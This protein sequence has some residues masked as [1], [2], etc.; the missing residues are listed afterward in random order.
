MFALIGP[1]SLLLSVA[2]LVALIH[3]QL[4]STQLAWVE[5]SLGSI[6]RRRGLSVLVCGLSALALRAALLPVVGIPAPYVND[7][8]SYLL[9]ADTFAHG[10]LTNPTHPMW[11]HFESFH[12]IFRPTYMSMY[13]PVQ[14]LIMAAGR[15]IGG[16]PFWGI[17]LSVG[18]MCAALCWMLQ[19]WLPP[20]WAL[21]GGLLP[22]MRFGVMS[23]WDD[24]YWGGAAP[25]LGGA[26]VLGALPRICR[27]QRVRDA[28][29]LALGVAILANTRPYEGFVLSLT[30]GVALL[31][32]FLGLG[33]PGKNKRNAELTDSTGGTAR[34]YSRIAWR[35]VVPIVLVLVAVGIATAYYFW[36]V[37]GNP[38]RMPYEVNRAAYAVSPYF[39]W[40]HAAPVPAYHHQVFHDFYLGLEYKRYLETRSVGG[41]LL[42][43]LRTIGVMWTFY[44][45]AVLTLPLVLLPRV[46][47]DRRTRFLVVAGAVCLAGTMLVIF[48]TAHYAAPITGIL[49]AVTLQGMRHLRT[50]RFENRPSGLFLVRAVVL[51]CLLTTPLEVRNMRAPGTN[52]PTATTGRERQ[53]L[54]SRLD[55]LPGDQLVLVRYGPQHDSLVEW[56][57]NGSDIDAQKIVWARDMGPAN[58]ELLRYYPNRQ[59]WLLEPDA[60]PPRLTAYASDPGAVAE[61]A[62]RILRNSPSGRIMT[63]IATGDPQKEL[64]K[65]TPALIRR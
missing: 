20:G 53:A 13:P 33:R 12:I 14:G 1:E 64:R 62:N 26:L 6:A 3:P 8:F 35:L 2:L 59:V 65:S 4:G 15:L 21:L 29:M 39:L 56:V 7:E 10:R 49:L 55:S 45:G 36:R 50:W 24:G 40:Q 47:R 46:L 37:T 51:I 16:S 22:V 54:I 5:R 19:G 57:Y 61:V 43:L 63:R 30:V 25:A 44:F 9:A 27:H 28:L 58:Q 32:W 41:F 34:L 18:A 42:N 17:W 11:V 52:G 38:F 48:F 31:V 60:A 23:Y